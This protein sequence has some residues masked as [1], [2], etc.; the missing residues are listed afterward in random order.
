NF[1]REELC[2]VRGASI[3]DLNATF[4]AGT[5]SCIPALTPVRTAFEVTL[6]RPDVVIAVLDSGIKWN[7][8]NAM[9]ALRDKVHLNQGELL[10]PRHDL[11]NALIGGVACSSYRNPTGGDYNRHGR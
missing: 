1:K 6:G 2:G 3:V 11:V 4:P 7:D 9:V 10:A 5:A 8:A